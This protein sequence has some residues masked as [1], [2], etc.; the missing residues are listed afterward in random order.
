V[1]KDLETL[2]TALY[3]KIDDMLRDWP[4]L[5]PVR[6]A[7]G[8][9]LTLSDAELL[10]MA[11]MSALLGFTS[12]RRWLRYAD[13]ELAGMFPRTIGQSGWNKR[14]RKAFFLFIRVIRML[15][16]DTSL[17][18][19]DVWVVDSTPVQCGCSRETVKRSDAAGWAEY[20]YCASH[21]RYFWGLRLHL[22]CTLTGLPVMFAL[23]GAKAD[24]RETLLGMLEAARDVTAAHPGQVIIGDK[25]YFGRAFEAEL[26][27]RELT[28]LRPV[29]KG[30]ARRAGQN[31]F[32]PLRQ[33][34]ESVNWTFKGQLDLERHGGKTPEGILVRVLARVL[35]LTAAIW[36]NDKTA[37]PVMRSLTA[38]DH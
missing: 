21:S 11:V 14:V 31:L 22:V 25:N 37:Q 36:H 1:D 10:T 30:E 9:P 16:M 18:S 26:T 15:A 27:E 20:G 7:A 4:D 23:A 5:A 33:V 32:K 19:D 3:V 17:W 13:K 6:P 12:E 29:R 28:L 2:A 38:Y 8:T 34:I 35:A 24:E